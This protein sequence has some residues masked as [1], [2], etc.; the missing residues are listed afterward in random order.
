M[1]VQIPHGFQT[2]RFL[3]PS[4]GCRT[5]LANPSLVLSFEFRHPSASPGELVDRRFNVRSLSGLGPPVE[6]RKLRNE[7]QQRIEPTNDRRLIARAVRRDLVR[8]VTTETTAEFVWITQIAAL[9]LAASTLILRRSRLAACRRRQ[10]DR[11]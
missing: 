7:L 10:D 2:R 8:V 3:A 9:F 1:E 6:L 4:T 5:V 11:R